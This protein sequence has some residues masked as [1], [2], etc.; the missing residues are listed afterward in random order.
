MFNPLKSKAMKTKMYLEKTVDFKSLFA[1]VFLLTSHSL[2]AQVNKK[3]SDKA[4]IS[5]N[6]EI[7]LK[8][9]L[10]K[11][12]IKAHPG[13]YVNQGGNLSNQN[14]A[15][16]HTSPNNQDDGVA[17][18]KEIYAPLPHIEGFPKY[19]STG[20]KLV[21]DETYRTKKQA[22]INENK[23]LYEVLNSKNSQDPSIRNSVINNK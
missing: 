13:D 23:I 5:I 2:L 19:E 14:S 18:R 15:I 3:T 8:D 1:F 16:L 11:D 4:L 6:N 12:W 7:Q 10:K 17:Q 22:W 20:N 21:D 9:Q